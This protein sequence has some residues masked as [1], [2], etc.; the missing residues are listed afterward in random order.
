M[1]I[2]DAKIH[3]LKDLD[4]GRVIE[5]VTIEKCDFTSSTFSMG[6]DPKLR[7]TARRVRVIE[8]RVR[9]TIIGNPIL[10][11]V[12]IQGLETGSKFDL[13]CGAAVFRHVVLAGKIGRLMIT[14][15]AKLLRPP[16]IQ[17]LFEAANKEFYAKVDWALDISEAEFQESYCFSSVPYNLV[18]RDPETQAVILRKRA[19]EMEWKNLP[20][21]PYWQYCLSRL[22]SVVKDEAMVFVAAI[23]S[24]SFSETLESL[25][26]LRREGIAEAD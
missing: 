11:E 21:T 4:S 13:Q 6:G 18:R 8:C 3:G 7:S 25:Q 23:H 17:E 15:D 2:A 20:L 22:V 19:C 9:A 16:R 1:T 5:D 10:D 24:S 12:E 26:L 14:G